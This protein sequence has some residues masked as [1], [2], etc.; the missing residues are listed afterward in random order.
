MMRIERVVEIED[1]GLDRAKA[2]NR[3]ADFANDL[4]GGSARCLTGGLASSAA[5]VHSRGLVVAI[6]PR[7][8][9]RLLAES[10]LATG[11]PGAID[12]TGVAQVNSI[13]PGRAHRHARRRCDRRR[14]HADPPFVIG[15]FPV[16]HIS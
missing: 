13:R 3:S 6:L 8:E 7:E 12:A 16:G 1:P 10:V 11:E 4:A 14:R 5:L 15:A 9:T 2:A